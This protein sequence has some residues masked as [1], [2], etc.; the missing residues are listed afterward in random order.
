M[1]ADMSVADELIGPAITDVAGEPAGAT[2]RERLLGR[3]H[4]A[5]SYCEERA[6]VEVACGTGQGLGLLKTRARSVCGCDLSMVN[7]ERVRT[8]Y[9]S[10]IPLARTDAQVL[11]YATGSLDIVILLETLYFLPDADAFLAEAH[12]VLR[13]GGHCLISAINKDCPDFNPNHPLYFAHY[14][15]PQLAAKLHS[16]GMEPSCFGIIPMDQPSVRSKVFRPLKQVAVKLNLIPDSMQ[17]RLLLKR[18][19]FGRLEPMPADISGIPA[20]TR[21][22]VQI[23]ADV[24]D[25]V[26]QV[27]LCA[28]KKR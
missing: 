22:P 16:N 25:T 24:P 17:A 7:L 23:A 1:S 21:P 12:R 13:P 27:V 10:A 9:G 15:A 18:I 6:V 8:T 19:V 5:A 28:G 20:P 4:W 11:P 26:H 2:Q 14:G 3:Y